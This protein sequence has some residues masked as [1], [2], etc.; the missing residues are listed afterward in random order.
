MNVDVD[1]EVFGWEGMDKK[2]KGS[3]GGLEREGVG[4]YGSVG[5]MVTVT[6]AAFEVQVV[7]VS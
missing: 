5:E 3:Q 7:V 2:G 1:L 6:R 4:S